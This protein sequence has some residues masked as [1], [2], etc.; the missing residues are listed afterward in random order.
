MVIS[1]GDPLLFQDDYLKNILLR[2]KSIASIQTLR[3]E[4]RALSVLPHRITPGLV[5]VLKSFQPLYVVVHVNHPRELSPEFKLAAKM[6]TDAGVPLASH[7]VL[8]R[9]VNDRTG[10]L[11]ELFFTLYRLKI[12]PYRLV[13]CA[14]NVGAEH[15]QTSVAAGMKLM[16]SLRQRMTDL[17]LPEFVVDTAGGKV[18]LRHDAVLSRSRRQLLVKNRQGKIYVYPEIFSR[19]SLDRPRE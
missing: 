7:S 12:R 14:A 18:P 10:I 4:T 13:H 11:S 1:G 9:G 3:I 16:E 2:L 6:L 5:Q 17:A 19:I 8:L 15:F